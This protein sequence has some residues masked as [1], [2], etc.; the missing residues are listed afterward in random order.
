M[1]FI[2]NVPNEF[3]I[4]CYKWT[5]Y[6]LFQ[7]NKILSYILRSSGYLLKVGHDCTVYRVFQKQFDI[8]CSKWIW[9]VLFQ[10]NS[11]STVPNEFDMYCC[12]LIELVRLLNPRHRR[13]LSDSPK[14][15]ISSKS[16]KNVLTLGAV[17]TCDFP[18]ES[19]YDSVYDLLPMVSSKL[20]FDFFLLKCVERPL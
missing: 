12:K 11:I 14:A 18:Y 2:S 10:M 5:R 17:Y 9:Y 20:I 1:S 7:I 6:V 8:Y 16:S 15:K 4:Y 3:D 19:P 13:H